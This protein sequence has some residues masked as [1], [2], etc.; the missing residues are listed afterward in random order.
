MRMTLAMAVILA[1]GTAYALGNSD[2]IQLDLQMSRQ[3]EQLQP[4]VLQLLEPVLQARLQQQNYL[5]EWLAKRQQ[6]QIKREQYQRQLLFEWQQRQEFRKFVE[7]R[8]RDILLQRE[9]SGLFQ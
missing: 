4:D 2:L 7:E 3:Q 6:E 9:Q 5:R 8:K 1:S